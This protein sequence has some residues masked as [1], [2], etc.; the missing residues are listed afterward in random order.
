VVL[1]LR[2]TIVVDDADEG[3]TLLRRVV[4]R[5]AVPYERFAEVRRSEELIRRRIVL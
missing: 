5:L 1:V 2:D 3:E 4:H